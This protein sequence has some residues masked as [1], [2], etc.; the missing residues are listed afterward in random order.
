MVDVFEVHSELIADSREFTTSFV[1][2]RDARV[3]EHV[4]RM[5][6]AGSQWPAP[7]LSLDPAFA[8]GGTISDLVGEG[9]LHPGCERIFQVKKSAEDVGVHQLRL[10]QHQRDDP[11]LK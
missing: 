7:W 4:S 2:P 3:R 11:L 5:L 9:L 6:E 1:D 10:H 8:S